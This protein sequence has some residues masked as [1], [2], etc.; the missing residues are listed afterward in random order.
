MTR[1]VTSSPEFDG[2]AL[3]LCDMSGKRLVEGVPPTV[4][5]HNSSALPFVADNRVFTT[6]TPFRSWEVKD[7]GWQVAQK[8]ARFP[9]YGAPNVPSP[10]EKFVAV[11]IGEGV[12]IYSISTI[13]AE[14]PE[15]ITVLPHDAAKNPAV[16]FCWAAD[17]KTIF[18]AQKDGAVLAWDLTQTPPKSRP[19]L[20]GEGLVTGLTAS[21]NGRHLAFVRNGDLVLLDLAGKNKTVSLPPAG[22]ARQASFSPDGAH[23]FLNT[24]DGLLYRHG[25]AKPQEQ[26]ERI[27]EVEALHKFEL[28]RD[29]KLLVTSDGLTLRW[30]DI[31][32]TP[33]RKLGEWKLFVNDIFFQIAPDSRHVLLHQAGT[34]YVLRL[35]DLSF[36]ADRK[37]AEYVL[38]IG[39][40][41]TVAEGGGERWCTRIADLPNQRFEMV[42]V[43]LQANPQVTE[44]GLQVFK[45]VNS[46]KVLYLN[47]T[48]ISDSG[49]ANFKGCK[50]LSMLVLD[51]CPQVTDLGL[52]NFKDC[53][54]LGILLLGSTKVTDAGLVHFKNWKN[55]HTIN[56][57]DTKVSDVGLAHLKD[58]KNL[59]SLDVRKTKITAA[60]FEELKKTFP[61][62][63]IESDYGTYD[64]TVPFK[65]SIGM[66]FVRVP[67][68]TGWLGG[69]AGKQGETKVVIEQDFY[70]GKYE[71]TQEEWEAVTGQNPSHFSRTGAGKDAV[72]DIPD[73]DLKRFPVEQV[74]WDDCQLF[75]KRLNEKEKDSGWVYRMPKEAEW[76]YACRGGPVDKVDSA[77]DFYFAKPTNTLLPEQANFEHEKALKRTCKVGLYEANLLG[78]HDMHGNIHEWCDD[79]V[80]VTDGRRVVWGGSWDN[81]SGQCRATSSNAVQPSIRNHGPL[82]LRLARVPVGPAVAVPATTAD[83]DRKAA[84]Y[85]LSIGGT[86][87]VSGQEQ[88]IKAAPE[89]PK[90]AFQLAGVGLYENKQVSDAGLANFKDCRSLTILY[91]QYS[92]PVT[93]AGLANFKDCKN[94]TLINLLG[95]QVTDA[96]LAHF[97]DCKNL[98]DLNLI[99]TQVTDAGLANFKDCKDLTHL[100]L[101]GCVKVSDAGLAHFKD[102]KNLTI[103]H[104]QKT[105]VTAAKFEEL[106][107]AF[108][109]CRIES[110]H[111]TYEPK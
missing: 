81:V 20:K 105:K 91:L 24:L 54:N 73:A 33:I 66:E 32:T 60:K 95:T 71:V 13:F 38:S 57:F 40:R 18:T 5:S 99:G 104:L 63:K 110:D 88:D 10:D 22:Q 94:L 101:T 58:C 89:L 62:C 1:I 102:C 3:N 11:S 111:G 64:P 79:A 35:P 25:T 68:G 92:Q 86:V 82:G 74:S 19:I 12:L 107:K 50:D 109:K 53:K 69:G 46:V 16:Q 26:P 44:T 85:V 84:E 48:A 8:G 17:N 76:E 28:S 93:D 23:L 7:G 6:T 51:L 65:N 96:G 75:I 106:K 103:L 21:N 29:G 39:G 87:R 72:K 47:A 15:P 70:L 77:F 100:H 98:T 83:P 45:D 49:L 37:A 97:K 61:K 14:K 78:L 31:S 9:G 34:V 67:K 108:P 59:R 43:T 27:L 56:L 55:L 2:L 90:E 30:Y 42:N 41:V 4:F 52:E 36:A 80:K